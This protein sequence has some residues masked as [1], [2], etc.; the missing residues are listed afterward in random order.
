M[1]FPNDKLT[2]G[3]AGPPHPPPPTTPGMRGEVV[4]IA[5]PVQLGLDHLRV[6]DEAWQ[7]YERASRALRKTMA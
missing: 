5:T 7:K 3:P 6:A 1:K 2:S 4:V